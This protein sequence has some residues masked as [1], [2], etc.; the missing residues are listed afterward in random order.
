MCMHDKDNKCMGSVILIDKNLI[1]YFIYL[2]RVVSNVAAALQKKK[3]NYLVY[4]IILENQDCE[5][6]NFIYPNSW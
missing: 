3:I 1:H 5:N 6:S 4:I 2:V